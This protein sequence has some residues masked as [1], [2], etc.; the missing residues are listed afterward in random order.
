MFCTCLLGE[1]DGGPP[2]SPLPLLEK[3]NGLARSALIGRNYGKDRS[4]DMG[5]AKGDRHRLCNETH[6]RNSDPS[7]LGDKV[8]H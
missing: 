1:M 8:H 4:V 2:S 6:L 7:G 3:A 5:R